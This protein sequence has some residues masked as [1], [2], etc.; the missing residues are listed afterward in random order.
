M[1]DGVLQ[2]KAYSQRAV[3]KQPAHPRGCCSLVVVVQVA[4][5]RYLVQHLELTG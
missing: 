4:R 3:G 2:G 5:V 1:L